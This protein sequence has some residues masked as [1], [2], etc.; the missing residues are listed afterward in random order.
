[1]S[2]LALPINYY[3]LGVASDVLSGL[4]DCLDQ[5]NYIAVLG[6]VLATP[7]QDTSQQ[8]ASLQN[9][10]DHITAIKVDMDWYYGHVLKYT[11]QLTCFEEL[12]KNQK[13]ILEA[14]DQLNNYVNGSDS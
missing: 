6:Y 4:Q 14:I 1:M 8:A 12:V 13:I 11:S 3:A 5:D 2:N 9:T 10:S 7:G